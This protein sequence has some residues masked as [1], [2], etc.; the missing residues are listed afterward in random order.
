MDNS[1][2]KKKKK[3]SE[4]EDD[5]VILDETE[6]YLKIHFN[7]NFG[8]TYL[9]YTKEDTSLAHCPKKAKEKLQGKSSWINGIVV[10]INQQSISYSQGTLCEIEALKQ[11]AFEDGFL[12]LDELHELTPEQ[13]KRNNF[14]FFSYQFFT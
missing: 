12:L 10:D 14:N 5:F 2:L 13:T 7:R 3:K 1:V 11:R 9:V 8:A 6:A 4:Q